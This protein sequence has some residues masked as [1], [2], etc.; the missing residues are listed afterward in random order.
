[1]REAKRCGHNIL[2]FSDVGYRD[3][4]AVGG[5]IAYATGDLG[6]RALVA[7]GFKVPAS[8]DPFGADAIALETAVSVM[9]ECFSLNISILRPTPNIMV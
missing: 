7:Q 5:W 8:H 3:G 1:M 4:V 9:L 6:T 2:V